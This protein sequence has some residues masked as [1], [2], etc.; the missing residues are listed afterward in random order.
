MPV[1]TS[2]GF[3]DRGVAG[4][5]FVMYVTGIPREGIRACGHMAGY[6][7]AALRVAG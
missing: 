6:R 2:V 1:V 3:S 5:F 7:R 4:V